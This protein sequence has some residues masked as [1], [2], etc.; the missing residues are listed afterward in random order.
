MTSP[1]LTSP[2]PRTLP[3]WLEAAARTRG[4]AVAVRHKVRGVWRSRTWR[5]VA[6][7]VRCLAVA[8]EAHGFG[9][10]DA[11]VIAG[12]VRPEAIEAALAAQWLGGAA[13]W[14]ESSDPAALPPSLRQAGTAGGPPRVRVAFASDEA[15]LVA[16]RAMLAP[17][18]PLA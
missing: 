18:A 10:G 8:F 12:C 7:E 5:R 16:L 4:D 2:S 9:K 6:A 17:G 15:K 1:P 13:I 11:I 3:E 14:V